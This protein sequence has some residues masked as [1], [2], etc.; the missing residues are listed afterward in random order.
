[1]DETVVYLLRFSYDEQPFG[2]LYILT[3]TD[4]SMLITKIMWL[5]RKGSRKLKGYAD[6]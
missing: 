3:T 2:W 6:Y 1:M 4:N 5:V